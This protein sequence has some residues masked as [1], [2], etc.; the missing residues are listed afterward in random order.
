MSKPGPFKNP[1]DADKKLQEGIQQTSIA[2]L[3]G[4]IGSVSA[5]KEKARSNQSPAASPAPPIQEVNKE[6]GKE[7]TKFEPK[8]EEAKV[9]VG[10]K[11]AST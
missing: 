10:T 5:A 9:A 1:S 3:G 6:A 11:P 4:S 8:A 7:V 2:S